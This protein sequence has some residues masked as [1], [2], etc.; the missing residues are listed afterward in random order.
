MKQVIAATLRPSRDGGRTWIA[1]AIIS[2]KSAGYSD[3][4]VLPDQTIL[5]LYE[6]EQTTERP[7]GLVLARHNLE[8]LMAK[9]TPE[10]SK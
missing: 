2:E 9:K 4:A 10:P 5:T 7:R 6:N 1:V 3:S 8:W